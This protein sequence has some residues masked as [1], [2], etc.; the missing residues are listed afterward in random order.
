MKTLIN[1]GMILTVLAIAQI[2]RKED[3]D[4]LSDKIT[5]HLESQLP[6]WQHRRLPPFG[7]PESKVVDQVWSIPN[8]I[9]KVAV[10][11]R[12][13]VEDAKKEIRSFLQFRREPQELSGFGDE[14]FLPD[15]NGDSLILRKGRYVIY[16][17]IAL[18][19]EE[20]SDAQNLT[21]AE[22]QARAK[23]ETKRILN[24]FARQFSAI[25]LE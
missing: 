12:G 2:Q 14:A 7:T 6:G 16:L 20:D 15:R 21:K 13:S 19:V 25:E 8:R 5:S 11:V 4:G 3:L 10:A 22:Q 18:Y 23:A 9:V 17:S 24:E 1:V